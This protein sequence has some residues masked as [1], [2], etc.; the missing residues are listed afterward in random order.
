MK[1]KSLLIA[2]LVAS[3]ALFTSG[4]VAEAKVGCYGAGCRGR[5]PMH[6]GC[7]KDARTLATAANGHVYVELRYSKRCNARWAR[8]ST[9][10]GK[11]NVNVV[12]Y[13]QLG[14]GEITR[15]RGTAPATWSRMWSGAIGA[16]GGAFKL[17]G[18]GNV[19]TRVCTSAR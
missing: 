14:T 7:Y 9:F 2:S 5:D 4:G 3:S 6:M 19:R 13:A 1:I 8:T 12:L 18:V 11:P 17:P 16:C 15:T 10:S